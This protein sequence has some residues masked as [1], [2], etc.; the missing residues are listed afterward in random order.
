MVAV[1]AVLLPVK[2][3]KVLLVVQVAVAH[4]QT[5]RVIQQMESM[6]QPTWVVAVAPAHFLVTVV[7]EALAL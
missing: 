7:L 1:V 4:R 3:M 2:A 6:A 5:L